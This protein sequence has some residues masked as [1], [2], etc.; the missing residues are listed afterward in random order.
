MRRQAQQVT[1]SAPEP[2]LEAAKEGGWKSW[3]PKVILTVL[4]IGL[5]YFI[6]DYMANN[7]GG[8]EKGVQAAFSMPPIWTIA[9]IVAAIIAIGVYPLTAPAAIPKLGYV[10]AFVDRQGG[11]AISTTIPFGG[12]PIAV[13]TQY[14]ILARYGVEQRL[15]AAAVAADAIWTYLMT[16][17]APGVALILLWI[18]ER[19]TLSGSECGALPCETID[20]IIIIA[21][22]ICLVS[23]VGIA[24][25]L[26]SRSNAQKVGEFAQGALGRVFRL[27]KRTPPNVVES[28]VGFNDTAAEMVGKRWIPITLTNILAQLTPMFVV[29]AALRG[30]GA[31]SV[32]VLEVFAAFSVALLLTTVPLAPGG[33]GTVD[34]ALIGMLVAFGAS[35]EEAV[36]ADV[37]WRAFCFLPQMVLGWMAVGYFAVRQRMARRK[38]AAPTG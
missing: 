38:T 14:A 26:R 18:F 32:T 29:L 3:L 11:F 25:V 31:E 33:A 23:M 10:P 35:F 37:I 17:G 2:V 16:F 1:T 6:F 24:F 21:G 12:G 22:V 30:V 28:V 4:G 27:I 13:A 7:F 5:A 36:A 34:A 9:A 8:F 20:L 15:A 19:R